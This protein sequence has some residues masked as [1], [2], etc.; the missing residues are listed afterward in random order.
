MPYEPP[1]FYGTTT[2][3]TFADKRGHDEVGALTK[4]GIS[5]NIRFKRPKGQLEE[6]RNEAPLK[7]QGQFDHTSNNI[8]FIAYGKLPDPNR[9]A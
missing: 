6:D 2:L 1:R 7:L 9:R 3:S 8:T 4:E 5:P